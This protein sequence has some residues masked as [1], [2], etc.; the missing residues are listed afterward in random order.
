M[1]DVKIWHYVKGTSVPFAT[2]AWVGVE[3]TGV[4]AFDGEHG[5]GSPSEGNVTGDGP[6]SAEQWIKVLEADKIKLFVKGGDKMRNSATQEIL[7]ENG[8]L[9]DYYGAGYGGEASWIGV[10]HGG[11]SQQ[12]LWHADG[13]KITISH[14]SYNHEW[15]TNPNVM[16]KTEVWGSVD[17]YSAKSQVARLTRSPS[18]AELTYESL[19]ADGKLGHMHEARSRDGDWAT[20][21]LNMSQ[22]Q[23][24][25]M[26]GTAQIDGKDWAHTVAKL[27]AEVDPKF[28]KAD[29]RTSYHNPG[30]PE[31]IT[32]FTGIPTREAIL[33]RARQP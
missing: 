1:K 32:A 14:S 15:E 22:G 33:C 25:S 6:F 29:Y 12:N 3:A 4:K 7:I 13:G 5:K 21:K 30:I 11:F 27:S 26:G 28:G 10:L 23:L 16:A 31:P 24:I 8:S 2:F 18:K 20:C 19:R 17:G 9:T